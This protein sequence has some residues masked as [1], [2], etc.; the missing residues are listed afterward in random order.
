MATSE[1]RVCT[2][3]L[4]SLPD[5]ALSQAD[6]EPDTEPSNRK[7]QLS[8]KARSAKRE[9][10]RDRSKTR[11]NVQ[12][13][14]PRWRELHV[15]LGFAQDCELAEHLLDSYEKFTQIA[16]SQ[17][18]AKPTFK[19]PAPKSDETETSQKCT[20][21]GS[22]SGPELK[23]PA[24]GFF[25]NGNEPHQPQSIEVTL[26]REPK[27]EH[28]SGAEDAERSNGESEDKAEDDDDEDEEEEDEDD[29]ESKGSD[30]EQK[31]RDDDDNDGSGVEE[32]N[33][34]VDQSKGPDVDQ[35]N[36]DDYESDESGVEQ[37]SD[38]SGAEQERC[39]KDS[40]N[41][42][43]PKLK[44]Q[45]RKKKE[46]ADR[47]EQREEAESEDEESEDDESDYEKREK[48]REKKW[49]KIKAEPKLKMQLC[50]ECGE[51]YKKS[52]KCDHKEKRFPCNDC[53]RR[54]VSEPA[55]KVHSYMHS[56]THEYHCK[57]CYVSFK[58]KV[59]KIRHEL[60]HLK[61]KD[62]FKCPH[63]AL[64]F[65]TFRKRAAHKKE[66]HFDTFKCK[67]CGTSFADQQHF[68][69][70]VA[71]HTGERPFEC[72]VCFQ[73]FKQDSHLKSHMR[74]HTGERPYRCKHCPK[75][76]NH[77]VCLKSHL[78]KYHPQEEEEKKVKEE[79]KSEQTVKSKSRRART[80][81]PRG[82]PKR[83]AED[84]IPERT[85]R[86]IIKL[87]QEPDYESEDDSTWSQDWIR[88]Y[89]ALKGAN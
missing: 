81:R 3:A 49:R 51:F 2:V 17:I 65:P 33:R 47:E 76:F 44:Y 63:C 78:K 9:R 59:D 35:K 12:K 32:K 57:F 54:F 19:C 22:S 18:P 84:E 25:G 36:R 26:E 34:E 50:T 60:I 46:N 77:N 82:R 70:H 88:L 61:Q 75:A 43:T 62:P 6:P 5:S 45:I 29:H 27:E 31:N 16:P 67:V 55:L 41:D 89:T 4:W 11:V 48:K 10:D 20:T 68:L 7:K 8:E 28:V 15:R 39:K 79:E 37:E 14:H 42:W 1:L 86:K 85:R 73:S 71:V 66:K 58:T 87:E 30:V 23:C 80:G 74:L 69:R 13:T 38:G 64:T 40:D 53:G 52:H 21:H 24:C 56:E 72:S 83:N